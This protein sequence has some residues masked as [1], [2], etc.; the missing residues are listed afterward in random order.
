MSDEALASGRMGD[1]TPACKPLP[2]PTISCISNTQ[3]GEVSI[4]E[5]PKALQDWCE[6]P[7]AIASCAVIGGLA[8]ANS[9]SSASVIAS[10]VPAVTPASVPMDLS[11]DGPSED[12]SRL[13]SARKRSADDAVLPGSSGKKP[14]GVQPIGAFHPPEFPP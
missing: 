13:E 8:S 11:P 9:D 10:S 4:V 5:F 1:A 12:P 6:Q 2:L 7:T 3:G 14:I